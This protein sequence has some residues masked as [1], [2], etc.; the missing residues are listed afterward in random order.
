M[1]LPEESSLVDIAAEEAQ[2]DAPG[3]DNPGERHSSERTYWSKHIEIYL[4]FMI[5]LEKRL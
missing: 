1:L 5:S 4:K 3:L 2:L